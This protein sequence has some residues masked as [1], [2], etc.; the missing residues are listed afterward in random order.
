MYKIMY[1]EF[2]SSCFVDEDIEW[3]R[4]TSYFLF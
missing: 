4:E 1:H 3:V 2:V